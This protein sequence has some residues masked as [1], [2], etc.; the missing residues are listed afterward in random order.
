MAS[1]RLLHELLLAGASESTLAAEGF[2]AG[3][4]A[5]AR[6]RLSAALTEHRQRGQVARTGSDESGSARPIAPSKDRGQ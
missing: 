4:R 3:D 1:T 5:A 6:A 2:R